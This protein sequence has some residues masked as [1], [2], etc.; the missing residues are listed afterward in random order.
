MNDQDEAIEQFIHDTFEENYRV[1]RLEAARTLSPAG[2]EAALRQVLLYWRKMH[3][4]AERVTDTEVR[5]TLPNQTS[6]AGH[7][8]SIHGV[9]DIVRDDDRTIMYDIKTHDCE[10][11]RSHLDLY[12]DQLNVY[13]HIWHELRDE[14]LDE[15]AIIGTRLPPQIHAALDAG[16]EQRLQTAL[17]S[18]DPL[19]PIPFDPQLVQETIDEFGRVV[20]AIEERHFTPAGIDRLRQIVYANETFAFRVCRQCDAR[21]SCDSYREYMRDTQPRYERRY[22]AYF[23]DY[24]F[25]KEQEMWQTATLSAGPTADD[26]AADFDERGR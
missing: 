22:W 17:Q 20:D 16:D 18:W 5:L 12:T 15:A 21:F 1:L 8:F 2:R 11:V 24:G 23:D 13:A 3:E 10:Y 25:D 6:P 19:V 14:P 9:V 26:L 4:V 7:Q